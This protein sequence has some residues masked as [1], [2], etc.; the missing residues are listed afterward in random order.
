MNQLLQPWVLELKFSDSMTIQNFFRFR[1]NSDS[2]SLIALRNWMNRRLMLTSA[3]RVINHPAQDCDEPHLQRSYIDTVYVS[4]CFGFNREISA[5]K[6][7][8][9][10]S[11]MENIVN[12]AYRDLAQY[13]FK[14]VVQFLACLK[15]LS[16]NDPM[17]GMKAFWANTLRV[18]EINAKIALAA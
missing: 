1:I 2:R 15:L 6:D 12:S 4:E 17:P 9:F 7:P 14:Y 11:N 8:M 10:S 16:E 5:D 3:G 13:R 18:Y